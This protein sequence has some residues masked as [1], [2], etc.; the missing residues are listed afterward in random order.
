MI[1]TR[2]IDYAL[3]I[4]RSLS[5]KNK[6]TMKDLCERQDIPKQFAYKIIKKLASAQIIK[7]TRG[8]NGG[9]V[10]IKDLDEI[11]LFD[12]I[13]AVDS[14]KYLSACTDPDFECDYNEKN[15]GLCTMHFN[16]CE[17]QKSFNENLKSYTM[18]DMLSF[19][20]KNQGKI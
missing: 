13:N 20:V 10:L 6:C 7:S 16:L 12:L 17:I 14:E 19:P 15:R 18:K 8:V 4:V 1:I 11:T 3:R 5:D 2:E 9:C